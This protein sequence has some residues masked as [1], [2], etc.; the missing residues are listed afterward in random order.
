MFRSTYR[1]VNIS[2]MRHLGGGGVVV[3]LEAGC[4][5]FYNWN[6]RSGESFKPLSKHVID[7][8]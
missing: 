8:V 6:H 1:F 5:P 3:L 7:F 2:M 4:F